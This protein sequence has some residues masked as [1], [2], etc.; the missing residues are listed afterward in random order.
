M[1]E[2]CRCG[3]AGTEGIRGAVTPAT[4][5]NVAPDKNCLA[6]GSSRSLNHDTVVLIPCYSVFPAV[7]A[8]PDFHTTDGVWLRE[9]TQ[10]WQSE[11]SVKVVIRQSCRDL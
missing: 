10:K 3:L 4:E 2:V 11:Q 5:P 7:L 6:P 8:L 1:G 9:T